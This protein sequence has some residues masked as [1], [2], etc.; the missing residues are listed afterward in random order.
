MSISTADKQGFQLPF[1]V[2]FEKRVE[3]IPKWLP[4]AT[5]I[6]SVV[7]AFIISGIV[8]KLIGGQPLLVG[9]VLFSSYLWQLGRILGHAG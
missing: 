6:G 2:T 1:T 4:A 9:T 7:V 3:D 5:S 8:L